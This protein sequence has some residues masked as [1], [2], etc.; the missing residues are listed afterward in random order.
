MKKAFPVLLSLFLL[1]ALPLACANGEKDSGL[2][3][4]TLARVTL[5]EAAIKSGLSDKGQ[6]IE[7]QD[8]GLEILHREIVPREKEVGDQFLTLLLVINQTRTYSPE[9]PQPLETHIT[10]IATGALA[11]AR[12][13]ESN[14]F[15]LTLSGQVGWNALLV[16]ET[17]GLGAYSLTASTETEEDGPYAVTA[18]FTV[19][20]VEPSEPGSLQETEPDGSDD[21]EVTV[22]LIDFNGIK[23]PVDQYLKLV[24]DD[25]DCWSPKNG[26][27]A[28]GFDGAT[29]FSFD[30]EEGECFADVSAYPSAQTKVGI[31]V[32]S[33]FCDVATS[34]IAA[35]FGPEDY[36]RF[37]PI[38]NSCLNYSDNVVGIDTANAGDEP[39]ATPSPA[40][41]PT[42]TP[43]TS[44]QPS[45]GSFPISVFDYSGALFPVDLF[46]QVPYQGFTC[47]FARTGTAAYG[48]DKANRDAVVAPAQTDG[49]FASA[50]GASGKNYEA[51][52]SNLTAEDLGYFC[53]F[54]YA[55]ISSGEVPEYLTFDPA[56]LVEFCGAFTDSPAP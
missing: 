10:G 45:G 21:S 14:E 39:T 16:C 6:W 47:W 40:P 29:I 50:S 31:Q 11:P 12:P 20:C 43:T 33:E 24:T 36:S 41:E 30:G 46:D 42:A 53:D 9:K 52:E 23:L 25:E 32:F 17:A 55:S 26:A 49:C 1:I 7:Y 34:R 35:D 56:P 22:D 8:R 51:F 27:T 38:L 15:D 13:N 28:F 48:I 3:P 5:S 19:E 44:S 37:V 2:D 18:D 54:A 4:G